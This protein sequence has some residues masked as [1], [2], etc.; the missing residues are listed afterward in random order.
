M[1]LTEIEERIVAAA[2]PDWLDQP[3]PPLCTAG[4]CA[5]VQRVW[6]TCMCLLIRGLQNER[7]A[8]RAKAK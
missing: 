3:T 2:P 1:R 8:E 7:A 5:Q 4:H 6:G